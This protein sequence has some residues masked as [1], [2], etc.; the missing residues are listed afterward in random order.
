MY[1]YLQIKVHIK[2]HTNDNASILANKP[3]AFNI[4]K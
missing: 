1:S 2:V 4:T 3:L